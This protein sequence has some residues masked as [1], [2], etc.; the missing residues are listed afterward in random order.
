[1]SYL[2]RKLNEQQQPAGRPAAEA[3]IEYG[4]SETGGASSPPVEGSYLTGRK[5]H[6]LAKI[7]SLR[8]LLRPKLLKTPDE[9]D[10]WH[11]TDAE[12]IALIGDRLR[13]VV[14]KLA[15][16]KLEFRLEALEFAELRAALL[17]DLLGFGAIEPLVRDK[18]CAEIMVN[19][20]KVIFAE[21][22]GKLL[23]TDLTFDDEDHILWTVHRIVR[24]LSRRLDRSNPMVDARLPD[25][26]R[27]HI[28]TEPSALQGTTIT[29]RKFPEKR[30]DINDL[31]G[32][33]TLS[34]E[35]AEFLRA[36]VQS[37]LNIIV[38]GGTG[39]G[40]TT[41]LN[42]L[43]AFISEGERIVTIEDAAELQ[44]HQRHVVRLETA[45]PLPGGD[46]ETG[47]LTI[48]DLVRGSLRMRPDRIIV[49]EC[50]SG[51]AL[52]MLQAM[53]TGHDGSLTTIHSNSPRDCIARLE[54]LVLMSGMDLP[55]SVIRRQIVSAIDL[56][57]QISHIKDGSR[58]ITQITEIQGME[59]DSVTLQDVFMYRLPGQTSTTPA[60][61]GGG[62]LEPTG[63]R[64]KVVEKLEES[65]FHLGG[66]IF[67]AG[68]VR[69]GNDR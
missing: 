30:L 5:Q 41:L 13:A 67:G 7:A 18:N 23:E 47:M 27:V 3:K 39:S 35:A 1:M 48:R 44:L 45:P 4:A 66:R 51:E 26:S 14:D 19:G 28:V 42:V 54:T 34:Q 40:K 16:E 37:R 11:R 60:T 9:A 17:D 57:V 52:D 20:P 58:K 49:G 61:V 56:I 63:F 65:G 31:L 25:G 29:I 12:K 33:G 32:F 10:Q 59:G 2:Q 8:K 50:R 6:T 55:V 69:L 36:C 15:E 22:R 21:L 24:P 62:K 64:P 38:S 43:S 53:N 68:S 46:G